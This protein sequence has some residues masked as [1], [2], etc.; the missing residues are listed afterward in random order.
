MSLD[1][2][3]LNTTAIV[4]EQD[5]SGTNIKIILLE[6]HFVP[7]NAL[8]GKLRFISHLPQVQISEK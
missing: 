5:M 7:F 3:L 8:F 2:V 1:N 6:T 4:T